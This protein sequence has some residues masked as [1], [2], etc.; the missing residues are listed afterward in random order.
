MIKAVFF[1]LDGTLLNSKKQI[2]EE[3]VLA[4]KKCREKDVKLFVATARPPILD[5]MLNWTEKEFGLFDGGIFCNGGVERIGREDNYT[6]IP[7][8]VVSYCVSETG[9]Y[10]ELNIALQMEKNIHAFNRFPE[11]SARKHWGIEDREIRWIIP[12]YMKKVIKILIYYKNLVDSITPVP[13]PLFESLKKN[14]SSK[15]KI[16]LT[17]QGKVIQITSARASKYNS[18]ENIRKS[19]GFSKKEIAVFGDDMNDL[20]MLSGYENSIAMGNGEEKAKNA[21]GFITL[22]NDSD[23]IIYGLSRY[24]DII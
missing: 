1:D 23:G 4:L 2:S 11:K 3:T 13:V 16:Y 5:R 20:E 10:P 21:A 24:L 17:D 9:K 15:T 6:Y 22:D 8:H 19:L 14:C 12:E 18:I 7:E